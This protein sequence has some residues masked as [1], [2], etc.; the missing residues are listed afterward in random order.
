MGGDAGAVSILSADPLSNGYFEFAE[1]FFHGKGP[2]HLREGGGERERNR[3]KRGRE[4]ET[5]IDK[6][7]ERRC[8][9]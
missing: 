9:R 7:E 2:P 4:G 5:G 1:E 6:E 8:D 3:E